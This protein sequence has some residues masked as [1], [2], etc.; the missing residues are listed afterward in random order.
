MSYSRGTSPP[1]HHKHTNTYG[2]TETFMA[3]MAFV[4][5]SCLRNNP[6][7]I[8]QPIVHQKSNNVKFVKTKLQ[9]S[10]NTVHEKVQFQE[11]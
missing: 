10:G 5:I 6:F 7:L 8:S 9:S 3:I 2:N 11:Y 1:P 4:T